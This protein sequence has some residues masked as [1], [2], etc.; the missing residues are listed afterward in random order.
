MTLTKIVNFYEKLPD[1]VKV[2]VGVFDKS[3]ITDI[4]AISSGDFSSSTNL[5]KTIFN[6]D[7]TKATEIGGSINSLKNLFS[8]ELG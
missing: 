5:L 7:M 1:N 3:L 8:V 6:G 2:D 4:L